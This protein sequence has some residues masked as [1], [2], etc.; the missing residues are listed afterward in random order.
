MTELTHVVLELARESGHPLGDR[1][2][3]YHLYVP[4]TGDGHIDAAAWREQRAACRVRRFRPGEDEAHGRLLHGPG[5]GWSFSYG[6][7]E[8]ADDEVG[9]RLGEECLVPGEYVSIR[10]DDGRLHTFQVI[11]CKPVWG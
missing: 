3:G 6:A 7:G 8:D 2:H 9:F 11:S 1:Q 10:E 4:L 5:G